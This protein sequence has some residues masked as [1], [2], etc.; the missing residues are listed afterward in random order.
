ML[1]SSSDAWWSAR[2]PRISAP[3]SARLPD[4]PPKRRDQPRTRASRGRVLRR[5]INPS[6]R[7]SDGHPFFASPFVD[8]AR[9]A[10]KLCDFR[11]V[12]SPQSDLCAA[13]SARKPIG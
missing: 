4:K 11:S 9:V 5:C 2:A 12:R 13:R 1:V 3:A 7:A 8:L 6:V 10:A